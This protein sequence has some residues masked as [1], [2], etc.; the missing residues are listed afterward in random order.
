MRNIFKDGKCVDNVVTVKCGDHCNVSS[1]IFQYGAKCQND[2][3]FGKVC[4]AVE[5]IFKDGKC[6]ENVVAVKCGDNCN[7]RSRICQ[8]GCMCRNGSASGR[9]AVLGP[10][11]S[12]SAIASK[13]LILSDASS[14]ATLAPVFQIRNALPKRRICRQGLLRQGNCLKAWKVHQDALLLE[15]ATEAECYHISI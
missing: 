2:K 5:K 3:C 9:F 13:R 4:C 7:G 1:R 14:T 15:I 11:S 12:R 6:V 10:R 8:Y